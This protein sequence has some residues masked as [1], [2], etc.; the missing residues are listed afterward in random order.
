MGFTISLAARF[1]CCGY[2]LAL[3]KHGF[4]SALHEI[5]CSFANFTTLALH[6][7]A[8]FIGSPLQKSTGFF[9]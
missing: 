3:S 8:A 2:L 5:S 4:T 6:E 1:Y 9:T 7:F